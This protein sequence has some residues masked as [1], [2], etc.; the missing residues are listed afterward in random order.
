MRRSYEVAVVAVRRGASIIS[1]PD[2]DTRILAG[3]ILV[4]FGQPD[5]VEALAGLLNPEK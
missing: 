1:N 5:R 3:D 2:G 4:A